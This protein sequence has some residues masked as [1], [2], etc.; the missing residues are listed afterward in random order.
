MQSRAYPGPRRDTDAGVLQ[1]RRQTIMDFVMGWT[2]FYCEAH[3]RRAEAWTGWHLRPILPRDVKHYNDHMAQR[4]R[5][6]ARV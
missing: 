4:A 1:R 5:Q 2:T 3:G 6:E